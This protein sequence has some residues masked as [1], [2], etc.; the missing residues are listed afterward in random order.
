MFWSCF[1]WVGSFFFVFFQ[2]MVEETRAKVL[3]ALRAVVTLAAVV[4]DTLHLWTHAQDATGDVVDLYNCV[5]FGK[6]A[7]FVRCVL[8]LPPDTPHPLWHALGSPE[9]ALVCTTLTA[10][11]TVHPVLRAFVVLSAALTAIVLLAKPQRA[12]APPALH[13]RCTKLVW[14]LNGVDALSPQDCAHVVTRIDSA[15]VKVRAARAMRPETVAQENSSGG[16][17]VVCMDAPACGT[18]QPCGH[19]VLC[20]DCAAAVRATSLLCPCCRLPCFADVD[21]V[22]ANKLLKETTMQNKEDEYNDDEDEDDTLWS[23]IR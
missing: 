1:V 15:L 7:C 6:L 9:H 3:C 20:R 19:A 4:V 18:L 13:S 21:V 12:P 22:D 16:T 11:F 14:D 8:L 23:F 17:C 5:V 2:K 10:A